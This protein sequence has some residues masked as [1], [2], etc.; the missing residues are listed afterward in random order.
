MTPSI[1]ATAAIALH[2][3]SRY[4]ADARMIGRCYASALLVVVPVSLLGT[5]TRMPIGVAVAAAALIVVVTHRAHLH[6]PVAGL[7]LSLTATT[8]TNAV[9]EWLVIAGSTV[10]ALCFLCLLTG[11]LRTPPTTVRRARRSRAQS[12]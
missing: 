7:P 1:A 10:Y 6:P 5:A 4:R 8:M 2:D 9:I 12:C 11:E 3:R